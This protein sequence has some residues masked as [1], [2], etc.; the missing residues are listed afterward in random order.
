[1]QRSIPQPTPLVSGPPAGSPR[2]GNAMVLVAGLLVLLVIVVTAFLTSAQSTRELASAQKQRVTRDVSVDSIAEDIA[3]EIALSLFARP[4]FK[5]NLP[6]DQDAN[7]TTNLA[8]WR[9]GNR[10]RLAAPFDAVRYGVDW[11]VDG[12]PGPD[13]AWNPAPYGVI[14]W[15]N[16]PDDLRILGYDAAEEQ[17]WPRGPG[18][19]ISDPNPLL[20]EPET[21]PLGDPGYGDLRWLS[22]AEPLS[23]DLIGGV[24]IDGLPNSYRMWRHMSYIARPENGWRLVRD[25]SNVSGNVQTNLR[26]PVE[27]WMTPYAPDHV[28]WNTNPGSPGVGHAAWDFDAGNPDAGPDY[29]RWQEWFTQYPFVYADP[30]RVPHNLY[31]LDDPNA[32]G[33]LAPAT[34]SYRFGTPRWDL[35]RVLDDADGDGFTDSFWWLAPQTDESGI[36]HVVSFRIVDNSAMINANV[37]TRFASGVGI[38]GGNG[39]LE[40]TRGQTPA[41]IALIGSGTGNPVTDWSTVIAHNQSVGF[42]DSL[43]RTDTIGG[44]LLYGIPNAANTLFD[45]SGADVGWSAGGGINT[46]WSRFAFELGFPGAD[47]FFFSDRGDRLLYWNLAGSRPLSPAEGI[48]P[49]GLEDEAELRYWS[50]N[51]FPW[52]FTRFENALDRDTD[53]ANNPSG[54][55]R[56]DRQY[57]ESAEFIN[58]AENFRLNNFEHFLDVR[59]RLTLYSGAR[60]DLKPPWLRWRGALPRDLYAGGPPPTGFDLEVAEARFLAQAARK[61]DL[62]SHNPQRVFNGTQLLE[63]FVPRQGER[64]FHARLA[65]EILQSLF[66]FDAATGSALESYFGDGDLT[67]DEFEQTRIMAAS[68]AANIMSRRDNDRDRMTFNW[69]AQAD[70][71]NVAP[72][73]SELGLNGQVGAVSLPAFDSPTVITDHTERVLGL[74]VQPFLT[75]ALLCFV[76]G[77]R[78]FPPINTVLNE[79]FSYPGS[80]G[81]GSV[82]SDDFRLVDDQTGATTVMAFQIANPFHQSIPWNELRKYGFRIKG[83]FTSF[84]NI[85]NAARLIDGTLP[86]TWDML[87]SSRLNPVTATVVVVEDDFEPVSGE[88]VVSGFAAS[89]LDFLDLDLNT[90]PGSLDSVV[91]RVRWSDIAGF[92]GDPDEFYCTT[93]GGGI[94]GTPTSDCVDAGESIVDLVR[95]VNNAFADAP[96]AGAPPVDLVVVDRMGFEGGLPNRNGNRVDDPFLTQLA[97]LEP[98]PAFGLP[99]LIPAGAPGNSQVPGIRIPGS[100]TITLLRPISVRRGWD[101]DLDGRSPALNVDNLGVQPDESAPR[102]IF[103]EYDVY[104]P[105]DYAFFDDTALNYRRR[106]ALEGDLADA[107]LTAYFGVPVGVDTPPDGNLDAEATP[108]TV[109]EERVDAWFVG[110]QEHPY[111]QLNPRVPADDPMTPQNDTEFTAKRPT[112]FDGSQHFIEAAARQAFGTAVDNADIRMHFKGDI[113]EDVSSLQMLQKDAD[114]EQVGEVLLTFRVGHVLNFSGGPAVGVYEGTERTFSELIRNDRGATAGRID[115]GRVLGTVPASELSNPSNRLHSV[116]SLAAGTRMLGLFVCDGA[117]FNWDTTIPYEEVAFSNAAGFTGR[118]TPGLINLNTASTQVM[119]ALPHWSSMIHEDETRASSVVG[120]PHTIV[121]YR[122]RFDNFT[123][124]VGASWGIPG[125]PD[126]RNRPSGQRGERGI[127]D[128]GEII[129]LNRSG[130]LQFPQVSDLNGALFSGLSDDQA[131]R[132]Q[133]PAI[134]MPTTAWRA[135]QAGRR[136]LSDGFDWQSTQISTDLMTP[137]PNFFA[138][139]SNTADIALLGREGDLVAG[140]V[141]ELRLLFNGASNMITTTSDMFTVYFRVRSFRPR[142]DGVLDATNRDSI[143]ADRR[144]VMLVDRSG[145]NT[146]SD[147]PRILYIQEVPD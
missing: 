50:G 47:N 25:I 1:M 71:Q 114:F 121:A 82:T 146:P 57:R 85:Y 22:D 144:Y 102:Y 14:P 65:D 32:N 70:I 147:Q 29:I 135:D 125:G 88:P 142:P 141:E 127:A 104:G 8:R 4:V 18:A 128:I 112:S 77:A 55:L 75:E 16:W 48:T 119:G 109:D 46:P 31:R 68:V 103:A 132:S 101:I 106:P 61:M 11:D 6:Q 59:H 116:P 99:N 39:A 122:E 80:G 3:G 12:I 108:I 24:G 37:A 60:N 107:D 81:T 129:N 73:Y 52:T 91:L 133:L 110:I 49:F 113:K 26:Y 139:P 118:A 36:R 15:T 78:P 69:T 120:F 58:D 21:N 10:A 76:H 105:E 13:V 89:W 34:D 137:D 43:F 27:Q 63:D 140:D 9:D 123:D 83:E 64:A 86:V 45:P 53:V 41:D 19:P 51:N 92:T 98:P 94:G 33:V 23:W 7:N 30:A 38:N 84:E 74:E 96:P 54:I 87:P 28:L 130:N 95:V 56:A 67:S 134:A 66:E 72:L 35:N 2:R 131:I 42:L 124:L 90:A 138:D 143:L 145:V 20:T 62:R 126:Y 100:D 115:A 79:D 93:A 136:P 117:G 17:L 97:R 40:A 111:G 44:G 5:G